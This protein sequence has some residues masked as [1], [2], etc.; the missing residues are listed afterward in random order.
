MIIDVAQIPPE[1]RRFAGEDPGS[2]LEMQDE[3][4]LQ[5]EGAVRYDL[6]VQVVSDEFIVKGT[7]NVDASFKCSRCTESFSLTV[8]E[9]CF[10]CV[11]ELD[12]GSESVDLTDEMREAILLAFPSYPV[13]RPDCRGL[14]S[15]CGADLNRMR[16]ECRPPADL[17]WGVLDDFK[18]E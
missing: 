17:R 13:C 9:K 2:I 11:R 15:Q 14:C 16:C 8:E 1:G 7:L 5:V 10:E 12:D 4:N 18:M 6:T 3:S